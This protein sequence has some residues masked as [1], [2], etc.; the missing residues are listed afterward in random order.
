MAPV[1]NRENELR[2]EYSG[3]LNPEMKPEMNPEMKPDRVPQPQISY[4][5]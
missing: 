5:Y 1:V 4:S 3:R 2:Q